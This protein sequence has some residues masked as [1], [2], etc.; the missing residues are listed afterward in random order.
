[1]PLELSIPDPSLTPFYRWGATIVDELAAYNAPIPPAEDQWK[2]WA[3]QVYAIP[4]V[5]EAG[6][7]SPRDYTDWRAWGLAFRQVTG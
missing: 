5:V 6:C 7:P 2:Q 1:M 3:E 4:E